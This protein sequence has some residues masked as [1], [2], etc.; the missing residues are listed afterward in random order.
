MRPIRTAGEAVYREALQL[1]MLGLEQ[2]EHFTRKSCQDCVMNRDRLKLVERAA[3]ELIG[4]ELYTIVDSKN[5]GR[6]RSR[7]DTIERFVREEENRRRN[8]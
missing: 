8:P 5:H 7:I 4:A 6:C 3:W 2:I 1:V